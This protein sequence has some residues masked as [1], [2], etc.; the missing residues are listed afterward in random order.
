VGCFF[1]RIQKKSPE[2]F[3]AFYENMFIDYIKSIAIAKN[4]TLNGKIIEQYPPPMAY[5][6]KNAAIEAKNNT[7]KIDLDFFFISMIFYF[8]ANIGEKLKFLKYFVS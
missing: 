7:Q 5:T 8:F 2:I 4:V 6:P 3:R 1:V